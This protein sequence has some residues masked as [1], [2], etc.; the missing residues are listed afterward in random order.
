MHSIDILHQHFDHWL[1]DEGKDAESL[2]KCFDHLLLK[3][4]KKKKRNHSVQYFIGMYSFYILLSN[5][6]LISIELKMFLSLD[7]IYLDRIL[8]SFI[9]STLWI[10]LELYQ[11]FLNYQLNQFY[12]YSIKVWLIIICF[13]AMQIK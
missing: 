6:H 1:F 13:V 7:T 8:Y 4:R 11:L 10:I 5:S 3:V 12:F 9:S 2:E